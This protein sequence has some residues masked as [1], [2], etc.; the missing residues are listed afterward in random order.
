MAILAFIVECAFCLPP[1][2]CGR[3]FQMLGI[4]KTWQIPTW[5]TRISKEWSLTLRY[6][7]TRKG[8]LYGQMIMTG[9]DGG[10][11]GSEY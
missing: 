6:T 1:D 3:K 5:E 10:H 9:S 4:Q 8:Q 7:Q 2:S 11:S